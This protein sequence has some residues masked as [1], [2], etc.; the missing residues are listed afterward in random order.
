[1][2]GDRSKVREQLVL[3]RDKFAAVLT[4]LI[5][6]GPACRERY[7]LTQVT[8]IPTYRPTADKKGTQKG[9]SHI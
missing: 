2:K 7:K 6:T 4:L 3:A 8:H 5:I 9:R 1:M